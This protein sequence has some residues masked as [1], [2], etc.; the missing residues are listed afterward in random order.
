MTPRYVLAAG[1]ATQTFNIPVVVRGLSK[2]VAELA[3]EAQS[4]FYALRLALEWSATLAAKKEFPHYPTVEYRGRRY[5]LRK[6]NDSSAFIENKSHAKWV[7][8]GSLVS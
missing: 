1:Q 4:L 8:L 7:P 6:L 3:I 2:P 5:E